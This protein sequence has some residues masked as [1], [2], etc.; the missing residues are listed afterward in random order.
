MREIWSVQPRFER[1]NGRMP[2]KLLE[3]PRFR[4][5]YDFMLLR[6]ESGEIDRAI[7]DWWTR[8]YDAEADER[9]E[10][11][12]GAAPSAGGEQKKRRRRRRSPGKGGDETAPVDT[13]GASGDN[14]GE[15]GT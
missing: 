15:S 11:T 2:F 5:A 9:N 12:S 3:H 14:A 8:F 4:A 7:G 6:A 10:L 1:M 13:L